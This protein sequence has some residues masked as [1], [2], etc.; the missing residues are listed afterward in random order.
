MDNKRICIELDMSME[1]HNIEYDCKDVSLEMRPFVGFLM[2]AV[3]EWDWEDQMKFIQTQCD[4]IMESDSETNDLSDEI[5]E[6]NARHIKSL[7]VKPAGGSFIIQ[8]EI[9]RKDFDL[10]G[11][12][13]IKEY[14]Q[15][16]LYPTYAEPDPSKST[17]TGSSLWCIC[18][19]YFHVSNLVKAELGYLFTC[20]VEIK[21]Y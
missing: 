13:S 14:K 1:A 6:H 11:T 19:D 20:G 15:K 12:S 4:R 17:E 5:G 8:I 9:D 16:I 21:N 3:N 18:T 2:K 7:N 10:N